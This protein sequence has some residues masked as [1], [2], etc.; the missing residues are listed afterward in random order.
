MILKLCPE[1]Y[2][3][4]VSNKKYW[5]TKIRGLGEI[6]IEEDSSLE[7]GD[8]IIDTPYGMMD[9]GMKVRMEKIQNVIMNLLDK[10]A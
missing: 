3:T 8:C 5:M 7:P 9:A 2:I 6:A 10:E 1:D 4:I